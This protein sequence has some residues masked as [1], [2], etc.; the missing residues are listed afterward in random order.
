MYFLFL[1]IFN[2]ALQHKFNKFLALFAVGWYALHTANAETINYISARSDS[3]STLCVI[4]AFIIYIYA[5]RWGKYFFL[6]PF[7]LGILIKPTAVMFAPLLLLY[8]FLLEKEGS[9][10]VIF[11]G[12]KSILMNNVIIV[13]FIVGFGLFF[14]TMKMTPDTWILGGSTWFHYMISQPFTILYYFAIFFLPI[15]LTADAGWKI[16][17]SITDYRV[18]AGVLFILTMLLIAFITSKKEKMRP[19]SFG[20]LWFFIALLPTSS[21]IPLSEVM[22]SHRVFFPYV[23]LL[24]AACWSIGLFLIKKRDDYFSQ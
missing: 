1:K 23:G 16:I 7:M 18:I 20:I 11:D 8:V 13:S 4:A 5:Q 17:T 6:I 14:F 22:N 10:R 19:V 21:V 15:G 2:T 3:L 9:V 12:K 24:F